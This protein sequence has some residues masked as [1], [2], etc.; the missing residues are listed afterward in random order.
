MIIKFEKY[1]ESV[2]S[3]LVDPT[4]D[5]VWNEIKELDSWNMFHKCCKNG[6]LQGVKYAIE[7][8]EIGWCHKYL[9]SGALE[10][11]IEDNIDIVKYLIEEQKLDI[12][13]MSD[14]LIQSAS[15]NGYYDLVLY[16]LEHG[17]DVHA[18]KDYPI[19]YAKKNGHIKVA[20][21][22]QEWMDKPV[23]EGVS[24]GIGLSKL[25]NILD[26]EEDYIINN[27]DRNYP[28]RILNQSCQINSMKGIELA[29]ENGADINNNERGIKPIEIVI[30]NGAKYPIVKYLLDN[31]ADVKSM[32]EMYFKVMLFHNSMTHETKELLKNNYYE[33]EFKNKLKKKED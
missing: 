16:L 20:E 13:F 32:S 2:K 1:N 3:L 29:L 22:I 31:G 14:C 19:Y 10:A 8:D 6:F 26:K 17:A 4:E 18:N 28:N 23:N 24:D 7:H 9:G 15:N 27:Y 21:L 5:E 30:K 11:T 12:H 25:R 33:N